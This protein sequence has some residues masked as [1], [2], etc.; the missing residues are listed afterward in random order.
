MQFLTHPTVTLL[1]EP[2]FQEPRHLPVRWLGAGTS[3]ERLAEF[4]GRLCYMSQR[5]PAAR[6]TAE[7]LANIRKE[8]HGSVFEHSNYVLLL[9]GVS[10]SCTHELVRHRAGCAYSQL[11]QRYADQQDAAIVVPPYYLDNP[12][13]RPEFEFIVMQEL[14]AY[15][16]FVAKH[17]RSPTES[18][19][20]RKAI[21]EAARAV[22]P[23]AV[24]TK[25]V[26]TANVRAWR[27]VLTT[28]ANPAAD[29]EIRRLAVTCLR[30]LQE[31][32][33]RFF[34]DFE[35]YHSDGIEAA[36]P[37]YLKV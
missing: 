32:A 13:L 1:S 25:L 26:M 23:P 20:Q 24:E 17:P 18:R 6:T 29:R 34:D 19:A 33:P 28:R 7:Y 36:R 21:R 16:N 30:V 22:L 10:R 4:A 11:S 35:I 8:G 5:N 12:D 9:E 27:H 15:R 3:G 37:H 2:T 14:E 31:A